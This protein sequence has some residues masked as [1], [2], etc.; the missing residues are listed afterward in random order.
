MLFRGKKK[1]VY[2]ENHMKHIKTLCGEK[3]TVSE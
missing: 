1:A 2:G 3:I